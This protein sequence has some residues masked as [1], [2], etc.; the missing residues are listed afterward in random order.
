[1]EGRGST[2]PPVA[3]RPFKE[4]VNRDTIASLASALVSVEPTLE[5]AGFRRQAVRGLAELELKARVAHVAEALAVLLADRPFPEAAVV[6]A[7]AVVAGDLGMWDGWPAVTWVERQGLDHPEAALAALRRVTPHM[8]AEFAVR[9]YFEHHPEL[10][11]STFRGWA[12]DP[13]VHVRRLVSEGSRPRLPWGRRLP[14]FVADPSPVLGLLDLLV[15]DDEEYVRRSVANNLNDI[16]KDHPEVA[17]ATAA[18]WVAAAAP[19]RRAGAEWIAGRGL[20]GLVK[21]GDAGALAVL[22]FDHGADVEVGSFTVA[23]ATVDM[24]DDLLLAVELRNGSAA[25]VRL[26]VDYLLHRVVADGS[27]SAKVFKW[28]TFSLPAGSTVVLEKRHRLRPVTVR[29]MHPGEHVIEVQVNGTVRASARFH[30]RTG[31]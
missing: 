27:T 8:S 9:P 20:R 14:A 10:T 11:L 26:V 28:R 18:R 4:E 25:D 16:A 2:I 1:M 15:D 24:G 29:T 17:V 7:D 22:G 31:G 12:R 5:V 30:L 19:D 13:D 21:A 23:P 6:V 3:D